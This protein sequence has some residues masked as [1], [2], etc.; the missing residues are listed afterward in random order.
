[1]SRGRLYRCIAW[2]GYPRQ[3]ESDI[4]AKIEGYT[5]VPNEQA[6]HRFP[7]S[8][9][10]AFLEAFFSFFLGE[11]FN[12]YCINHSVWVWFRCRLVLG[13][14][15]GLSEG[16]IVPSFC[17]HISPFPLGFELGGSDIPVFYLCGDGVHSI[18]SFH[19]R[20]GNSSREEVD[21][22][23]FVSDFADGYLVF[24]LRY[25]ISK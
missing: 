7:A 15:P 25:I 18:D 8:E 5:S 6:H 1:M 16:S 14:G 4:K 20:G 23:V 17:N 12:S 19:E 9:A 11:F 10:T 21:Q 2:L 13:V 3:R 24:E 22:G